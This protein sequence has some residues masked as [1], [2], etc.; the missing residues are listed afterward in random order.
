MTSHCSVCKGSQKLLNCS[1]CKQI[2]Y[3]GVEHQKSDWAK[4][5]LVCKKLQEAEKNGFAKEIMKE[6]TGDL[7]ETRRNVT[8]HY[9]GYLVN[10][11]V[12]DSSIERNEPFTFKLGQGQVIKG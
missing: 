3:C 12:F 10:G 11:D 4:H 8:V 6:G 1:G 9:K 7:P 2:A 5:K